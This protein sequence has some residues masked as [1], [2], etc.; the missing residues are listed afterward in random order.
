MRQ[1]CVGGMTIGTSGHLFRIAKAIVFAMIALHVGVNGGIGHTVALHHLPVGMTLEA[2]LGMKGSRGRMAWLLN[3]FDGMEIMAVETGSRIHIAGSKGFAMN[4]R[5]KNFHNL[6]VTF[7]ALGRGNPFVFLPGGVN[8]NIAMTGTAVDSVELVYTGV[9]FG[10]LVFMAT[11][12][13]RWLRLEIL[14]RM[15]FYVNKISMTTDTANGTVNRGSE[16]FCGHHIIVALQ[17]GLR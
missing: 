17:T 14:V 8:V 1:N 10:C 11:N 4:R 7:R 5:I 15:S 2:H 13:L 12:A 16:F 9:M 3:F 6:T